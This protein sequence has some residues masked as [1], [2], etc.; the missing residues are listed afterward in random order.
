MEGGGDGGVIDVTHAGAE[1]VGI[2]GVEVGEVIFE[3]SDDVSHVGIGLL[4]GGGGAVWCGRDW[5]E[6]VELIGHGFDIEVEAAVRV[7]NFFKEFHGFTRGGEEVCFGV[8]EWLH[9]DGDSS[10]GA[11]FGGFPQEVG[12]AFGDV[13]GRPTGLEAS[14]LGGTPDHDASIHGLAEIGEVPG[15]VESGGPELVVRA[16]EVE[17]ASAIEVI[18]FGEEPM[19]ADDFQTIAGCYL[20]E[21]FAD[22]GMEAGGVA[23]RRDGEGGDFKAGITQPGGGFALL[24]EG[25]V[26]EGLVAN[27][28][29]HW[30]KRIREFRWWF[31][32]GL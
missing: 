4:P 12:G 2:V 6:G 19:E 16:G 24:L 21:F 15:V 27:G 22:G 32:P 9:G 23:I 29:F 17:A 13:I 28:E 1:K 11:V 18:G 3:F 31:V 7:I 5:G 20:E 14:L 8:T 25:A 30:L 26:L 10:R